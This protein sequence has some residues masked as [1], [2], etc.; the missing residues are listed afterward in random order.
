VMAVVVTSGSVGFGSV[1]LVR[2]LWRGC[3]GRCSGA[4]G[5][6]VVLLGEHGADY[7]DQGGP[8]GKDADDVGGAADLAV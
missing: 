1:I 7:A 3:L 8:V 4:L 6:F 2:R 5:S